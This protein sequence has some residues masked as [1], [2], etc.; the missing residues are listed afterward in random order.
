METLKNFSVRRAEPA[1]SSYRAL[2]QKCGFRTKCG[3]VRRTCSPD[4][5]R[6]SGPCSLKRINPSR[7]VWR[8]RPAFVTASVRELP[9]SGGAR[10][11]PA[12][13][14]GVFRLLRQQ[15]NL[16]HRIVSSHGDRLAHG[17][18]PPFAILNHSSADLQSPASQPF[19]DLV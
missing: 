12:R 6:P 4:Q 19:G 9:S 14:C 5:T 13:L 2:R 1:K 10:Q 11:Q 17:K 3:S 16:R 18:R 7:S 15:E 8:S